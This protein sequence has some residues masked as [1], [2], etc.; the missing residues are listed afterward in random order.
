MNDEIEKAKVELEKW[1]SNPHELGHKPKVVEYVN[2]FEDE[3]GI[4]WL[5]KCNNKLQII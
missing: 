2:S 3:D 4:K 1:L 5:K